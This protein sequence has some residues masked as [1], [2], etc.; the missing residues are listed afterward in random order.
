MLW[1]CALPPACSGSR[2]PLENW[3]YWTCDVCPLL[4][5]VGWLMGGGPEKTMLSDSEPVRLARISVGPA[6]VRADSSPLCR[7]RGAPSTCLMGR[8][9]GCVLDEES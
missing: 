3:K 5:S 9:Q 2:M 7:Q 6:R 1:V 4:Q 8:G